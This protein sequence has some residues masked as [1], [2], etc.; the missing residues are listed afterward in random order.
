MPPVVAAFHHLDRRSGALV[1]HDVLHGVTGCHG[2]IHRL[3]EFDFVAA[4]VARI[5][6]EDGDAG[7]VVDAIGDGVGG[8][9]AEDDRMDSS[10]AGAGQQGDGQFR[11]H[12]H[13]D[14]HAVALAD[15][16]RL[17][18]VRKPL[19]L[20][21]EIGVAQAAYL[22]RLAFPDD[23]SLVAACS[24]SVAVDAVVAEIELAAH[25]P[26][27][28]GQVPFQHLVPGLEPVQVFGRLGPETLRILNRLLVHGLV[29]F[30]A[31]DVGLCAELRRRRKDAVFA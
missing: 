8:E 5:L 18:G 4:P 13:V 28:P 3:L 15:A 22:A 19:H 24:E 23:G 20:D 12:A 2:L 1:D 26:L 11:R 29:L 10:D 7:R 31:L 25:E 17:E 16:Q 9:S 30:E 14:G 6:G 21:V 27:G